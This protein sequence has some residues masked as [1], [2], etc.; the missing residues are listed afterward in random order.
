[1]LLKY[2]FDTIKFN[3]ARRLNLIIKPLFINFLL[4]YR[5]N[6]RCIMCNV[7]DL[8]NQD[9]ARLNE[10]LTLGE[11]KKFILDNLGF[12]S[13]LRN[14]G[15][16]G[17]DPLLMR[18]DFVEIVKAIRFYLPGVHLGVQTNGLI[19]ELARERLKEILSFCQDFSLAV[20]IDGIGDTHAKVRGVP[21]AFK[22]AM[23]TIKYAQEIGISNIT[24]G[25]TINKYNYE[26]IKDVKRHTESLGVEFSCFPPEI[27]GYFNNLT[28]N[29]FQLA[30]EE[31]DY[32]ARQLKKLCGYHYYMD[33]LRL[34]LE[35]KRERKLPCFSGFTSLVIDPY[36][37]V[38]PCV[39]KVVALED[40]CFGNI[41]NSSL[42][43][44]LTSG[45]ANKIREK[46]K[47]CSCWCQCEVSSSVMICPSDMLRWF[48]F[49]CPDK[50]GFLRH[51]FSKKEK[52]SSLM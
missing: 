40:D 28:I 11:I 6:A 34:Q 41:K 45:H 43:A 10:E 51:V 39:L 35:G 20:S 2:I 25:M 46:I 42:K 33:N 22:K 50:K 24:A 44:M 14:L 32:V 16:S 3:H 12:L 18:N 37:N 29:G 4:T 47:K 30:R 52:Y 9:P 1:M 26:E 31:R 49:Y 19:P 27:S 21:G 36:G 17:G 15:L 23:Q 8:Y 5:C 48:I 13:E 7:W 38:K